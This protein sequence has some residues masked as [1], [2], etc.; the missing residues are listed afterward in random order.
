MNAGILTFAFVS[1][2]SFLV[3]AREVN[4]KYEMLR[5]AFKAQKIQEDPN[6]KNRKDRNP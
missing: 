2:L 5:Q 4:E 3:C 1:G 6:N